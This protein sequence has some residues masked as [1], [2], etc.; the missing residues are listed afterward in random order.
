MSLPYRCSTPGDTLTD[1][2]SVLLGARNRLQFRRQ[3]SVSLLL[4]VPPSI[5]V[6]NVHAELS[7]LALGLDRVRN[8]L[9]VTLVRAVS[10]AQVVARRQVDVL[11]KRLPEV[12]T[13]RE[14]DVRHIQ[15][16]AIATRTAD[17]MRPLLD[18]QTHDNIGSHSTGMQRYTDVKVATEVVQVRL[19]EEN[20]GKTQRLPT[21]LST[22]QGLCLVLQQHDLAVGQK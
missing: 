8:R 2:E 3:H 10:N 6:D 20:I 11:A 17:K 1:Q 19:Q 16:A 14:R 18:T 22:V 12:F 21:D 5:V 15:D 4:R 13:A 9:R 7:L